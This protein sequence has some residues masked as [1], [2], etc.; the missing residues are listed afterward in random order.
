[1][2][3]KK[4]ELRNWNLWII[5][6]KSPYESWNSGISD[7]D[8]E[9]HWCEEL[10]GSTRNHE[11]IVSGSDGYIDVLA[12]EK[13]EPLYEELEHSSEPTVGP[14]DVPPTPSVLMDCIKTF[15]ATPVREPHYENAKC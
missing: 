6:R 10:G 14:Y 15:S 2:L 5:R 11:S 4:F 3:E 12:D 9:F 1:L 13:V 8:G 7:F